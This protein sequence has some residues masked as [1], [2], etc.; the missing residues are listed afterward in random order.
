MYMPLQY[1]DWENNVCHPLNYILDDDAQIEEKDV[2]I[3]A[4]LDPAQNSVFPD[5]EPN[6]IKRLV[7]HSA[8]IL[9]LISN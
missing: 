5:F 6:E 9:Q 7:R 2:V 1:Y 3:P 4:E 8:N